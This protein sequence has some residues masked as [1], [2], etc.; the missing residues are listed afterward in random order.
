MGTALALAFCRVARLRPSPE[1]CSEER[2]SAA[3][4]CGGRSGG[5]SADRA[6]FS[7]LVARFSLMLADRTLADRRLA[8]SSGWLARARVWRLVFLRRD[9]GFWEISP[10]LAFALQAVRLGSTALGN[11]SD[12]PLAFSVDAIIECIPDELKQL[13]LPPPAAAPVLSASLGQGG[14]GSGAGVAAARAPEALRGLPPPRGSAGIPI[15]GV[16]EKTGGQ[17]HSA[18]TRPRALPR[19]ADTA[20]FPFPFPPPPPDAKAREAPGKGGKFGPW[21]REYWKGWSGPS[22]LLRGT[23]SKSNEADEEAAARPD[24]RT[25]DLSGDGLT[26]GVMVAE[27]GAGPFRAPP[28]LGPAAA[29]PRALL[30]GESSGPSRGPSRAGSVADSQDPGTLVT[31]ERTGPFRAP[32]RLPVSHNLPEAMLDGALSQHGNFSARLAA[33]RGPGAGEGTSTLPMPPWI[34]LREP[35]PAALHSRAVVL[36]SFATAASAA[37]TREARLRG[38]AVRSPPGPAGGPPRPV[39]A[40]SVAVTVRPPP[41]NVERIWVRHEPCF[42]DSS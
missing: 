3:L 27:G 33:L 16:S 5:G 39:M 4:L 8:D 31:T 7:T 30:L 35:P 28:R 40:P 36:S 32:P 10:S 22:A 25:A 13:R 9:P 6:F 18:A 41:V 38:E 24:S 20:S 17:A 14:G 12:D 2:R 42:H 37:A 23:F 1:L 19:A 21:D 15:Y 29:L 11:D 34:A 26:G